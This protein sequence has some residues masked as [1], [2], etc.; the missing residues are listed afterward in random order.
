MASVFGHTAIAIGVSG[1]FCKKIVSK[2]IL[3]LGII[4]SVLPDI[5]VLAYS[6]GISEGILAHRGL[7]HS[8]I[9]GLIWAITLI[10]LFHNKCLSRHKIIIA[11]YYFIC[12]ASHGIIDGLTNG[13]DGITY[14][15]PF[16]TNR[17]F[18]PW[19]FIEVSPIGMSQFFS[20]WGLLVLKSE[21]LYLMLPSAILYF[22]SRK[23]LC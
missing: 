5:D 10:F 4:S 15:L 13:G 19:E 11:A 3:A 14:F 12:I 7:T 18:L 9:F 16:S 22:I 17:Y 1:P 21:F 23:W 20:K 6:K 8:P 2:K